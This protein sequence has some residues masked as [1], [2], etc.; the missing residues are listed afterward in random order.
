VW[1]AFESALG[2]AFG[3]E[4]P[5]TNKISEFAKS[6]ILNI[7]VLDLLTANVPVQSCEYLF[8]KSI[9]TGSP[10]IRGTDSQ[11]AKRLF[12]LNIP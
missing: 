11:P 1:K 3:R 12:N 2:G 7:K 8:K 6:E 10:V 4:T 5:V 9:L